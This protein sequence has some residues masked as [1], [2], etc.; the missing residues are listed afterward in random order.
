MLHLLQANV[1]DLGGD[2]SAGCTTCQIV[3]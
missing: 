1:A 2:M 3:F